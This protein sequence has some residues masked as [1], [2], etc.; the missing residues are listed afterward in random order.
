MGKERCT[1]PD[2]TDERRRSSNTVS[3]FILLD[4]KYSL[5]EIFY[6]NRQQ[7]YSSFF[8]R[9]FSGQNAPLGRTLRCR[10]PT[11]P[12]AQQED[13]LHPFYIFTRFDQIYGS[14]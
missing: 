4:L 9:S 10:R 5:I 2:F 12:S 3:R 13:C 6:K 11:I 14:S 1:I 8:E 7:R